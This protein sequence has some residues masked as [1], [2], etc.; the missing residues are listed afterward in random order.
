M[1]LTVVG[2]V[3]FVIS[4]DGL[5]IVDQSY[6]GGIQFDSFIGIYVWRLS[7]TEQEYVFSSRLSARTHSL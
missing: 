1:A 2:R 5:T 6:L 4:T 7:Y 3:S